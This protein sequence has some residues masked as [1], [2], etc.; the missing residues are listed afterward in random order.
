MIGE[1]Q[2]RRVL[3]AALAFSRADQTEVMI[4]TEQSNLTRFANSAIHQNVAESNAEMR[5][6]VV[7]GQRVGVASLNSLTPEAIKR[8]VETA[9]TIAKLQEENPD[10]APLPRPAP[11]KHVDAYAERTGGFGPEERAGVVGTICRKVREKGLSA[12]GAFSTG[13]Y[14]L[15]IANSLGVFAY[16]PSTLADIN[17]VIAA[18][19]SSGYADRIAVDADKID[20]EEIAA[21]AVDKALRGRNP[22]AVE[23][24]DYEV[25]L[26]PYAVNDILDF[27]ADCGFSALAVQEGRS[28]MGDKFG[29]K[30]VGDHVTIWDDG[31]DPGG[32]P[33]PFDYEGV[34]KEKVTFIANGVA[35]DVVYDSHTAKRAGRKSTG[36]SLPAPNTYGPFPMNMFMARGTATEAEMVRSTRK[37]ILVSRFWYTRTVHPL[38]V[39]VTGM[40]RDGTFLIEN[41]EITRPI[42]NL[43]FTQSYLQALSNLQLI[44]KTTKLQRSWVGTSSVPA[45]K[46]GKWTFSSATEY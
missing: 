1:S 14:E 37:G 13:A 44:G 42:K 3:E 40:T 7:V 46:I 33:T 9:I 30:I 28:F 8:V 29:Q 27:L 4:S 31:L 39:I 35:N 2:I 17:T 36:H 24:G 32:I 5:V 38:P 12:A 6:R 23:P 22:I 25:V 20:A 21:E 16:H 15:A 45:L 34:P 18:E 43:R 41:G 10:L 11:I 19:D 26:Q